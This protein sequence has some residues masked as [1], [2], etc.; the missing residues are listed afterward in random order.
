MRMHL[1]LGTVFSSIIT[2]A[3]AATPLSAQMQGMPSMQGMRGGMQDG[4]MMASTDQ[5][6][7]NIDQSL[8]SSTAMMRDL[9]SIHAGM[10]GHA[11][12]DPM[13]ATMQGLLDNMKQMHEQLNGMMKDP[14]MMGNDQAM[15]GFQQACKS[16]EQMASSFQSM[17]KNMAAMM[18]AAGNSSMKMK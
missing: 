5:T 18:R 6:M 15:K 13:M 10:E 14:T 12:H 17:T 1:V 2:L 4:T 16:L 8:N 11:Q 7:K 3:V 9:A